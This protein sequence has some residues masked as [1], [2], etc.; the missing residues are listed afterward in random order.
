MCYAYNALLGPGWPR[1]SSV[2][3][4]LGLLESSQCLPP[5]SSY[6]LLW[7]CFIQNGAFLRIMNNCHMRCCATVS[8]NACT[9]SRLLCGCKVCHECWVRK[10]WYLLH[11]LPGNDSDSKPMGIFRQCKFREEMLVYSWVN[12]VV[13]PFPKR[14][15][16]HE[17]CKSGTCYVTTA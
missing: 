8:V 9:Y 12:T 1:S 14:T 5:H 4:D 10:Q 15:F 11:W 17:C 7:I 16:W 13:S 2:D 6:Y 3:G